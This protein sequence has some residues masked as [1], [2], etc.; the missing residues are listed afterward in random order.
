MPSDTHAFY[1]SL[2]CEDESQRTLKRQQ[3]VEKKNETQKKTNEVTKKR[4]NSMKLLRLTL[5]QRLY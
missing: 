3:A 2:I 4:K 5:I 1:D